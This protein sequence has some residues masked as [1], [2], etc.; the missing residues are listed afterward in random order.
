MIEF[1]LD[2]VIQKV[3]SLFSHVFR[4]S[5]VVFL[6]DSFINF[7]LNHI[8]SLLLEIDGYSHGEIYFLLRQTMD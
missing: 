1:E 7:I 4:V 2:R 5:F 3:I 8:V 6:T